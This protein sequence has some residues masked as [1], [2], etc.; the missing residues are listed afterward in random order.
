M[1]VFQLHSF[2]HIIYNICSLYEGAFQ[3]QVLQAPVEVLELPLH[4]A[5]VFG[6]LALQLREH[7]AQPKPPA[8]PRHAT[9]GFRRQNTR[10]QETKIIR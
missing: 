8:T 2:S 4:G 3:V 7:H 10:L 5:P 9:R 1:S 6:G